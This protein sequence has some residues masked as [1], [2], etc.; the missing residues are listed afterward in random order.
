MSYEAGVRSD[1]RNGIGR[2]DS[3]RARSAGFRQPTDMIGRAYEPR[4]GGSTDSGG[5]AVALMAVGLQLVVP[6][7]LLVTLGAA[8]FLYGDRPVAW[9]GLENA[10]WLTLGHL[11]VPLT[12]FAIALTNRR[13]GAGYAMA[14]TVLAWALVAAAVF[15]DGPDLAALAGQA[16]PP[17]NAMLGFGG[18]LFAGHLLSVVVFDRTR[19]PRW[20]TAPFQALLWGGL[21]FCL[22]AFPAL[23]LGT[24]VDW[25]AR[26]DIYAGIM[27]V[28]AFLLLVPYW[29]LRRMVPPQSGFGGY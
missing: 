20:W 11:M 29:L 3:S 15:L 19:G 14:Q 23:Y 2:Y 5:F 21:A 9:L 16:L 22:I 18:A 25:F 27:S 28:S 24:T 12:F 10:H 1:P 13:Y 6:V 17:A 26:L 7:L 8:A 4:P